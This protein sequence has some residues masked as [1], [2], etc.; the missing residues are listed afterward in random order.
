MTVSSVLNKIIYSGNGATTAWSFPFPGV[1]AADIQVFVTT[2]TG[3]IS[4]IDPSLYSVALNAAIAPN[5]T[6]TGG[7]VNYP[8]TGSPLAVGNTLT[9]LRT[10]PL[11]QTVS[12]ANQ[13]ALY[14][15][16]IE[17]LEDQQLMM[18]Q[19]LAELLSRQITVAVSDP[20][21]TALPPVAQRALLAFMFDAAGN[22]IA[23]APGGANSPVSSAMAPVVAAAS[24]AAAVALLGLSNV[25]AEPTGVMKPWLGISSATPPAGYLLCG[26]QAV[27]RTGANAALFALVGVIFGAGDGSTTFNLPDMRGRVPAGLDNING[28]AANRL[29]AASIPAG[30]GPTILGGNG[31]G[32]TVT[33]I[34]ANLPP[35]SLGNFPGNLGANNI[36]G[37]ARIQ[38]SGINFD[39]TVSPAA[40]GLG[41]SGTSTPTLIVQPTI[42]VN[43][44][45]KL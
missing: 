7:T 35:N 38:L 39:S 23:A 44:I 5:P 18:I 6:G 41:L 19:Q 1:T 8:L 43:W 32:E 30:S 36:T 27:S 40:L 42:C 29:T 28:I 25:T 21:P 45:V 4:T 16:V 33:L 20:T 3:I 12:L 13:G 14:Q 15:P 2:S 17:S 24:I 22:P 11:Q 9:I 26:G 10:L 37:N 31:G 34:T